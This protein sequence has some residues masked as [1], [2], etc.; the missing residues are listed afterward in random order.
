MQIRSINSR[1]GFPREMGDGS[2]F[3]ELYLP[4]EWELER[5]L[6]IRLWSRSRRLTPHE[7]QGKG[8]KEAGIKWCVHTQSS[9]E[10]P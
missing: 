9:G 8:Q 5:K 4:E 10:L 6:G 1:I 7:P 3:A 2:P